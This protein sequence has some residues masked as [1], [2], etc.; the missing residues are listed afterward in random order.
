MSTVFLAEL[1][2]AKAWAAANR[3]QGFPLEL[4]INIDLEKHA[5]RLPCRYGGEPAAF[6]L[7]VQRG[8]AYLDAQRIAADDDR[9]TACTDDTIA[10]SFITSARDEMRDIV[11]AEIAAAVLA[12]L[13]SGKV[14]TDEAARLLTASEAL[15]VARA[16]AGVVAVPDDTATTEAPPATSIPVAIPARVVFK[17]ERTLLLASLEDKPRRFT[18]RVTADP[19]GKDLEIV[20]LWEHAVGAATVHKLRIGDTVYELDPKGE[21]TG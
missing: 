19:S 13:A 20:A 18:V 4:P 6:E 15:E 9:R 2:T 3:T 7:V 14:W 5:G 11:S 21:G 16:R 10:V 17:G 1:P 12:T 8:A